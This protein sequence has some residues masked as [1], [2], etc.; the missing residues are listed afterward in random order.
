M[1]QVEEH[2]PVLVVVELVEGGVAAVPRAFD[3]QGQPVEDVEAES[4]AQAEGVVFPLGEGRSPGHLVG[5][6]VAVE[7][8]VRAGVELA[9]EVVRQAGVDSRGNVVGVLEEAR[10][11][12]PA[13]DADDGTGTAGEAILPVKTDNQALVVPIFSGEKEFLFNVYC[14]VT[15]ESSAY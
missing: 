8:D 10:L 11:D 3:L 13:A 15:L 4:Q 1:S 7:V 5:I 12:E 2:D 9:G 14:E 6:G